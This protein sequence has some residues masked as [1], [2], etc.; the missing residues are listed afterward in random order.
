MFYWNQLF[1]VPPSV[2]TVV[3]MAKN[4]GKTVT[5]NYLQRML[6]REKRVLGLLSIGLDGERFDALTRLPK[7]AVVVQ[8]G[9]LVA[10]AEGVVGNPRQWERLLDT[11]IHTPVGKVVILRARG[12]Q[13]VVLAGP[14]KN[15][16]VRAVLRE[17]ASLGASCVIIDGAFDRQSS[18]DPLVS[19]QVILSSGAT[20][21]RE[22]K[23]LVAMTKCRVEQLALPQC[24]DEY[25]A[26]AGQDQAKIKLIADGRV[27]AVAAAT[28]LLTC[29]EWRGI[30]AA[31]CD[32]VVL[33]GAVGA[34]LGEALL[35]IPRPPLVIVQDGSKIF[36]PTGLWAR[37]RLN[38]VRFQAERAIR[39]LGVTVNPVMP[40]GDGVDPEE[41]LAAM[42]KA[43][44]PLP[45]IDVVREVRYPAI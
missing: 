33:K 34:G 16:E 24:A 30:L 26:L 25:L 36:I 13:K 28:T 22:I 32:A 29:E 18:A 11:A 2:L 37:L 41:L 5:M 3:G 8:P 44:S 38:R 9:T 27:V 6:H 4:S 20:L 12:R 1:P 23:A 21:S 7:P 40:G 10:T 42:G 45:V 15:H 31:G 17:L 19:D 43:L 39:L 35:K 14:S